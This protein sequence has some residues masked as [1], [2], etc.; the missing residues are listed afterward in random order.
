MRKTRV[1]RRT[2]RVPLMYICGIRSRYDVIYRQGSIE[3][4]QLSLI[5]GCGIN[6]NYTP[7][8]SELTLFEHCLNGT[9]MASVRF[10]LDT[11]L[12]DVDHDYGFALRYSVDYSLDDVTKALVDFG[13]NIDLAISH[14]IRTDVTKQLMNLKESTITKQRNATDT[15]YRTTSKSL[16]DVYL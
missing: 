10:L 9:C 15:G 2:P 5:V 7:D 4:S 12:V 11:G 1:T 8:P 14:S 6:V 13:A 3:L 16:L